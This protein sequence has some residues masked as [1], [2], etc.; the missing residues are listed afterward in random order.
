MNE[1]RDYEIN[2]RGRRDYDK[3]FESI[4]LHCDLRKEV[5]T[6]TQEPTYPSIGGMSGSG[7]SH[8]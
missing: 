1:R 8:N 3:N 6:K 2:G 4:C 7:G 5:A